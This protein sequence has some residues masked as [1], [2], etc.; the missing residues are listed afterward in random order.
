M[1]VA[2]ET[3]GS[4]KIDGPSMP[5]ENC[6]TSC[7]S[8]T[9]AIDLVLVHFS[10]NNTVLK[11]LNE[12]PRHGFGVPQNGRERPQKGITAGFFLDF[13]QFCLCEGAVTLWEPFK[14]E[15]LMIF[16]D[17]S[18]ISCACPLPSLP[19]DLLRAEKGLHKLNLLSWNQ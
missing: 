16:G 5:S 11:C 18:G 4:V 3:A 6:C 9:H 13:E 12:F 19:S 15:Y 14:S 8:T 7:S 17:F 1:N 10:S 2:R